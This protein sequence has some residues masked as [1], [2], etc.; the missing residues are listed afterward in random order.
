MHSH[1][2]NISREGA[3]RK[4]EWV[5][6]TEDAL[7][8]YKVLKKACMTAPILAFADYTKPFLMETDASKEGL[9]AVLLQK[10]QMGGTTPLPMAAG[11]SHLI[12]RTN[13]QLSLSL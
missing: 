9:G 11:P 5:S 6:L 1:S 13:T 12:G 2:A 7:N 4:S 8:A 10:Q 3:S